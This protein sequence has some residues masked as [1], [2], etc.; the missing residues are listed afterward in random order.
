MTRRPVSAPLTGGPPARGE[1]NGAAAGYE[2]I[3]A[4]RGDVRREQLAPLGEAFLGLE[5]RRAE[6]GGGGGLRPRDLG[7]DP[8]GAVHALAGDEVTG[9]VHDGDGDPEAE[10]LRLGESALDALVGLLL[11]E[12]HPQG[13]STQPSPASI[14]TG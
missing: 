4:E 5:R 12:R 3:S 6:G 10:G 9:V 2:L 1:R 11:R 13:T 8:E 14:R 7:R